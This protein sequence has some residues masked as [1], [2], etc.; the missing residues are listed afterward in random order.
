MYEAI[1]KVEV[2]AFL[3]YTEN[4]TPYTIYHISVLCFYLV[5]WT[6]CL[7]PVFIIYK[8]VHD[9]IS[10][11]DESITIAQEVHGLPSL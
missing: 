3:P 11:F 5:P 1:A 2:F 8:Y 7:E 4:L 9:N 6:L 10:I